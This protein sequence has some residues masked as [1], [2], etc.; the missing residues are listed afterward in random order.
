MNIW[1]GS[2]ERRNIGSQ[3]A[4][5]RLDWDQIIA[6]VQLVQRGFNGEDPTTLQSKGTDPSS[7]GLIIT[8]F[9]DGAFHKTVF[10][11]TA[12]ELATTAGSTPA[13]DGAWA[14][15]QIYTF[16]TGSKLLIASGFDLDSLEDNPGADGITSTSDFDLGLGSVA[17]AQASAF[18]LTG[19]QSDY[20]D[21]TVA[22]VASESSGDAV[23]VTT[24]AVHTVADL[25]LN[26][27]T[28]AETDHGATVAGLLKVT[29]TAF[30]V[31]TMLK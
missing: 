3:R 24:A 31:W 19:T 2:S 28:V 15:E 7:T 17:V 12:F 20:G 21:A 14:S 1:D 22:L 5:D 25:L 10:T 26:F 4:P 13:T 18:S 30:V 11:F 16:P 29:G 27:R 8:E 23:N 6:E 9:G